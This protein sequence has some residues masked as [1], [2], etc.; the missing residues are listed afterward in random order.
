[1]NLFYLIPILSL[2]VWRCNGVILIF[3]LLTMQSYDDFG[4]VGAF[5]YSF[6][7]K[8]GLFLTKIKR[9]CAN[10]ITI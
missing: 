10:T 1:M 3:Y 7:S 9:L 8:K 2:R 4:N 6:H 5:P